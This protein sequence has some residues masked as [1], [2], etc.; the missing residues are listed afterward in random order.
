VRPLPDP[1]SWL[2]FDGATEGWSGG[3][4]GTEPTGQG[5]AEIAEGAGILTSRASVRNTS[6]SL[7]ALTFMVNTLWPAGATWTV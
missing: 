3:V 2:G 1:R 5:A 4:G 7:S 6:A